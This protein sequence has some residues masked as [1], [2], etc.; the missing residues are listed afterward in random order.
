MLGLLIKLKILVAKQK[1]LVSNETCD[2]SLDIVGGAYA[3]PRVSI[4][5]WTSASNTLNTDCLEQHGGKLTL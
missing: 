1:T 4:G 2:L 3:E 5:G